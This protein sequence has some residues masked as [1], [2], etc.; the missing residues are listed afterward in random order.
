MDLVTSFQRGTK[1]YTDE[2]I[3]SILEEVDLNKDGKITFTEFKE[4]LLNYFI[5]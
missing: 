2:E 4:I 1:K 5:F 3:K